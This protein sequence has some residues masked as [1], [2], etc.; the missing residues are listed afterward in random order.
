V[1]TAQEIW[2]YTFFKMERREKR[3]KK[4]LNILL[5]NAF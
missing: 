4:R 5:G 3:R 2:L 1:I